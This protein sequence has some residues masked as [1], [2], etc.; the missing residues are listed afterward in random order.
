MAQSKKN[1][2]RLALQVISILGIIWGFMFFYFAIN[3]IFSYPIDNL[4]G[5]FMFSAGGLVFGAY[6]LYPSYLMLRGRSF[7]GLKSIAALLAFFS[8]ILVCR[9]DTA[10]TDTLDS[11]T[12]AS[13]AKK[14]EIVEFVFYIFSMVAFVLVYKI[15]VKF[16]ERLRIEAYSPEEISETQDSTDKQ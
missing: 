8:F 7:G 12:M 6:L 13:S 11:E 10:F 9:L 14:K 16:L 1:I 2:A 3:M 4:Y 5:W 15:S